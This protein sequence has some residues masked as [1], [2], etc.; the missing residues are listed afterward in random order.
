MST[1][2]QGIFNAIAPV[3]DGIN[4]QMTFG[5]HRAWKKLTVDFAMVKPGNTVLDICCGT[6]DL[7]FLLAKKVGLTGQVHAVDFAPQI[8]A[9]ARL[10]DP[11]QR[12]LWQEADALALPFSDNSFD[13]ITLGFGLRNV[14]DIRACLAEIRRVLRPGAKAA[15]LDLHRPVDP[16]WRALQTWYLNNRVVDLGRTSGLTAEYAYIAGSVERFLDGWQQEAL[17]LHI[18]F[19]TA[20]HHRVMGGT[21]GILVVQG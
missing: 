15:I 9:Q 13:A 6:G 18:G 1:S 14:A 4:D 20:R 10:R 17:A 16:G 8:L 5:L 2:V 3:Y 19:T 12:I 11:Q 21:I 7:A